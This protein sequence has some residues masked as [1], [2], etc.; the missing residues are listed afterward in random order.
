MRYFLLI[1]IPFLTGCVCLNPDHKKAAPPIANTGEVIS[2]LEKTKT[3]LE[4]AGDS[5][6]L[7]GEKVD[8]AL[9]LAE[10]LEKLLEQIE[11]SESKTIK[12]PI[13]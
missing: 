1:I 8:K 12:E 10:R 4:K 2:S 6:T 9:T 7:V 3:E 5:N 11:Q 13:K